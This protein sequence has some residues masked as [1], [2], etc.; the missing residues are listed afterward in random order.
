M[1]TWQCSYICVVRENILGAK[2]Q[3]KRDL[4][5]DCLYMQ[6]SWDSAVLMQ[7]LIRRPANLT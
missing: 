6:T 5:D 2:L 7:T 4:V 1:V 3:K